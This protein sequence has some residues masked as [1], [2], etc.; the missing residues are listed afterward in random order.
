MAVKYLKKA[1]K[2]PS[3]DDLKTRSVV[4]NMLNDIEKRREEGIKEITKKFD[5][6][7]G[8]IVVSKEKIEEAIKK[9]DQNFS[10]IETRYGSGYRWNVS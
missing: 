7:E 10:A 3:T 4:Q 2:T 8:A 9:V 1:I 6:Y 5:K